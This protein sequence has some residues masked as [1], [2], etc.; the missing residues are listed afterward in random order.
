MKRRRTKSGRIAIVIIA[1]LCL[2]GYILV[3]D[4]A[5]HLELTRCT[6]T[7]HKLSQSFSGFKI[8]QLSD[9]HGAELVTD[10]VET[11][12]EQ[13]PDIIALT[14]DF[15]TDE[16][17][18][19]A[20]EQLVSQLTDI[21][22]VYFISGNHDFASGRIAELSDI[23][24]SCGVKYLKNEY[25][26]I[27]RG[28]ESI[29]LA[30]V[31]DPNSWADLEPPDAFL[32]R[33]RAEHPDDYIVLLGHRNYWMEKYPDLPVELILCGHAHGGIVRIPGVGGLLSTDRTLFPDY[34][35]GMYDNGNYTMIVS[36][37]LGNSI[38]VPRLM[39]RPEIVSIELKN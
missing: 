36:R 7:N 30:G 11:V 39:N 28:G 18:L 37:G 4:S 3:R 23:L 6:V 15:I 33:V 8:V 19:P 2:V 24:S 21:C 27:Q 17:D 31:E 25:V 38:S 22:E 26:T 20:V 13:K 29:V 1:L 5:E 14:G 9:F 32:K 16:G 35:A 34:E 10:I 12:R